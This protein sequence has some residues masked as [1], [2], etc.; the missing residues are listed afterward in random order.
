MMRT[1]LIDSDHHSRR[2]LERA[3]HEIDPRVVL[4]SAP[5][6]AA[7]ESLL[8][9][10][11]TY[12]VALVDLDLRDACGTD[13]TD[14]LLA[15]C[16]NLVIVALVT[17]DSD[18]IIV[19]LIRL[20]LPGYLLKSEVT[21]AGLR[22]AVQFAR[23]RFARERAL[24]QAA[25]IDVV[26]GL[27][28][29]R[30]LGEALAAQIVLAEKTRMSAAMITIDVDDFKHLNDSYGHPF[31]DSVLQQFG[32]RLRTTVRAHDI[33]GRAGGDE[34]WV[35]CGGIRDTR[36][37]PDIA[38]KLRSRFR[39]PFRIGAAIVP[40]RFTMGIALIPEHAATMEDCLRKSDQALYQAKR[41]GGD[42]Y[43]MYSKRLAPGRAT[44]TPNDDVRPPISCS[45]SELVQ[46]NS[47]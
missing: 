23:E 44:H 33:V 2:E 14:R 41:L 22:R 31:G 3:L 34:F 25:N 10:G 8:A 42:R 24:L 36:C 28:N 21:A 35:V 12:D 39:R 18:N 43:A 19:D 15:I 45:P 1:L 38:G 5:S 47:V 11:D 7:A 6:L 30:G 17:E 40:I 26:T 4:A 9:S 27:L 16:P 13:V 46:G 29:R 37:V 32:H 20:G